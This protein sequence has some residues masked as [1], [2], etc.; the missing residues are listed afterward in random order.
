MT[1]WK[2]SLYKTI[3]WR[4]IATV[5]LFIVSVVLTGSVAL[6]TTLSAFDFFSKTL[7]YYVHER[8][9]AKIYLK[10]KEILDETEQ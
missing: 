5:T 3:T 6:A 1:G 9:W 8:V 7:L 2:I 4:I 10:N